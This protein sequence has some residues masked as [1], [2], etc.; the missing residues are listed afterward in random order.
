[1]TVTVHGWLR[2]DGDVLASL[3]IADDRRA[4]RH[5]LLGRDGVDGALLLPACRSVHT[6][7]MGFPIDVALCAANGRDELVVRTVRTLRPGRFTAP[8]LHTNAVIEAEVG[9]FARWGVV[10]G[11]CLVVERCAD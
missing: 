5:G 9:A 1:V 2:R 11:Q 3:E 4:R 10:P 8:R 7:G 6:F